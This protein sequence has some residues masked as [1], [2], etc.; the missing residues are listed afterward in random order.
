VKCSCEGIS[1]FSSGCLVFTV[2]AEV[3]VL[4]KLWQ[5]RNLKQTSSATGIISQ[6]GA[7]HFYAVSALQ[8]HMNYACKAYWQPLQREGIYVYSP[9]SLEQ[10]AGLREFWKSSGEPSRW[11]ATVLW[12][13]AHPSEYIQTRHTWVNANELYISLIFLMARLHRDGLLEE[14]VLRQLAPE[15]LNGLMGYVKVTPRLRLIYRRLNIVNRSWRSLLL[16]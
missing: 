10:E 9:E 3:H 1:A 8:R 6:L 4:N 11:K 12:N 5:L 13:E 16:F 2:G 15:L 7:L 14:A